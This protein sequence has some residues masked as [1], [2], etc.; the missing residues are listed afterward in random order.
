MKCPI[1]NSEDFK[2]ISLVDDVSHGVNI[3]VINLGASSYHKYF[4]VCKKCKVVLYEKG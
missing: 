2:T 3:G 4:K 1:C